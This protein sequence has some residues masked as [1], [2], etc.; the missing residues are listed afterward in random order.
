MRPTSERI[1]D[2]VARTWPPGA[3]RRWSM[4]GY[5]ATDGCRRLRYGARRD[6]D[7]LSHAAGAAPFCPE[8]LL[9]PVCSH[10]AG[11]RGRFRWR[12]T[13]T[14]VTRLDTYLRWASSN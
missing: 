5:H 3:G 10:P 14:L 12:G 13:P 2:E 4:V 8:H 6:R 9:T 11:C 1:P 7:F